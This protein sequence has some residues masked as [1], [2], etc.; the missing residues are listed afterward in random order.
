MILPILSILIC[1]Y[2]MS[3]WIAGFCM[4]KNNGEDYTLG[5]V[6]SILIILPVILPFIGLFML[7]EIKVIGN[8]NNRN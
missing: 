1:V 4:M 6:I 7:S 3:V 5:Q 8:G 2:I